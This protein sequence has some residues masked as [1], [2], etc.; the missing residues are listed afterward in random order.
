MSTKKIKDALALLSRTKARYGYQGPSGDETHPDNPELSIKDLA[1]IHE[2]GLGVPA[3]PLIRVTADRHRTEFIAAA[4]KA[5]RAVAR[6]VVRDKRGRFAGRDV[7]T[8]VRPV[9]QRGLEALRDT[10]SRSKEWARPNAQA[11]IKR[12]GHDHP[13]IGTERTLHTHASWAIVRDG[14]IVDQ[15]GEE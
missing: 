10:L 7:D 8:A 9:A 1:K 6:G 15:G 5:A 14:V 3:R 4:K 2:Y 11:T 13:L 12:K